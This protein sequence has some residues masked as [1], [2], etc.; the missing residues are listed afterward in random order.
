M[1]KKKI[2]FIYYKL[3]RAGGITRVLVNLVNELVEKYDITL[4]ILTE[5]QE[6]FYPIDSRVK[7]IYKNIYEHWAYTKLCVGIDRYAKW[8]PKRR[9]IKYYLVDFAAHQILNTWLNKNGKKYDT[10]VT[11]MYKLSATAS[12]NSKVNFKTIGWEHTGYKGRGIIF[13]NILQKKLQKLKGIITINKESLE[14]YQKYGNVYLIH[15]IVGEPF[16]SII[17]TN[18]ENL[19]TYVGRLDQDKNVIE[20]LEIIKEVQLPINWKLQIIG[21]GPETQNLIQFVQ[22][23]KLENQVKFLGLKNIDEVVKLLSKSKIF[24]FTSLKEALPTVLI[25]ALF[26]GNVLVSYDCNYGPSSIINEKNGFLI[27]LRDKKV[28]REK[29]TYLI[30]NPKKLEKLCASAYT[31]A[32]SWKKEKVIS[33]WNEVLSNDKGL[34]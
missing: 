5:K 11:C 26:C 20:L 14:Y 2:L 23:N 17:K 12:I 10:I 9:N 34:S 25:E 1:E 16:E 31:S 7:I 21:D 18:K 30:Q 13:G 32:E 15:N 29:L 28:F 4:L 6:P 33:H 24:A 22:E 19:I 27:P 8:I 3:Y